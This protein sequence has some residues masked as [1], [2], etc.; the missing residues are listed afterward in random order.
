VAAEGDLRR[1]FFVA[2]R[3]TALINLVKLFLGP[4]RLAV[5]THPTKILGKE[6][7]SIVDFVHEV[8]KGL[9]DATYFCH[10]IVCFDSDIF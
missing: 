10:Q 5:F 2:L 8:S 1:I 7:E 6:L 4:G 3:M 9:F